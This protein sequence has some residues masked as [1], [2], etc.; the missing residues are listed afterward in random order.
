MILKIWDLEHGICAMLTHPSEYGVEGRLAMIDLGDNSTNLQ[1]VVDHW[2]NGALVANTG[3]QH[4]VLTTRREGWIQFN[5]NDSG[6]FRIYTEC[7]G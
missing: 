2:P 6:D 5:V 1:R 4:R 3:K 7:Y